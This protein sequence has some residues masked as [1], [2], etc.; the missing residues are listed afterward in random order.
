MIGEN[1]SI[2][3]KPVPVPPKSHMDLLKN[4]T[5]LEP[6]TCRETLPNLHKRFVFTEVNPK[7]L[8]YRAPNRFL[9]TFKRKSRMVQS[10]LSEPSHTATGNS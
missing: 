1:R 4:E 6:S 2:R 3:D 5:C 8:Q 9:Q 7:M 10:R